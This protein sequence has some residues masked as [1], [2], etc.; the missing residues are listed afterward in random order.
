VS[1]Q[2]RLKKLYFM[3]FTRSVVRPAELPKGDTVWFGEAPIGEP[4]PIVAWYP[5][6]DA[7]GHQFIYDKM[8]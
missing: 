2:G 5:V 8:R 4:R 6:G 7:T 3:G 1:G